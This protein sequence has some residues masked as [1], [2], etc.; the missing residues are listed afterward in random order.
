MFGTVSKFTTALPEMGFG[1]VIETQVE[2]E[3]ATPIGFGF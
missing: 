1:P 3:S 2:V